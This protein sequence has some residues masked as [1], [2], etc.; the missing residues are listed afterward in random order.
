V[1]NKVAQERYATFKTAITLVQNVIDEQVR[2]LIA[3]VDDEKL[4]KEAWS[5]PTS[6]DLKALADKAVTR[7]EDLTAVA[8]KYEA[9]LIAR[10]WRV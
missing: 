1:V 2:G 4:P 10:G 5:L 7:I 3:K 8:K 9:E 6:D